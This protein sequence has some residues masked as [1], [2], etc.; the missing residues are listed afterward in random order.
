MPG[1]RTRKRGERSTEKG[2]CILERLDKEQTIELMNKT[3]ASLN[4]FGLRC[5][6]QSILATLY[7]SVE[8][9]RPFDAVLQESLLDPITQEI[10]HVHRHIVRRLLTA[11]AE[12]RNWPASAAN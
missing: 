10:L 12:A 8:Q 11:R 3:L 4:D 1:P 9:N 5:L 6:V 2:D 7:R